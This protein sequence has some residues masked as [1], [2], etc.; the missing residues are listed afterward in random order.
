MLTAIVIAISFSLGFFVESVIGFGGGLIAYSI[1]GFFVEIKTMVL[2]GLYIGT[3]ASFY[4]IFTDPK[5]FDKKVFFSI[6]PFALVG[7]V[8]GVLFFSK[9]SSEILKLV[10]GALLFFLAAKIVFF[11]K[12]SLPKFLKNKLIFIGGISQGCFGIGGPFW[13]S[14]LKN[15]FKNKSAL[16]ATMAVCFASFN[17]VRVVQLSIQ[18]DLVPSFFA[19][20]WWAILP[21]FICIKLGHHVHLKIDENLF[22]RMIALMVGLSGIKFLLF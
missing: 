13:V 11:D 14:A 20:I 16:R 6:L 3:C 10:F 2:S 12:F 1:L 22:K 9:V 7:T 17:L 19:E 15:D 4:I 18:G 21:V 8:C 5:S